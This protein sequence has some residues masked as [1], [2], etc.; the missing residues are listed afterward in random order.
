[1][2]E[3]AIQWIQSVR[4]ACAQG[5]FNPAKF[6]RNSMAVLESIPEEA[7][8]QKARTLELGDIYLSWESSRGGMANWV[9]HLRF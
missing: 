4:Q 5:G 7:Y 8:A 1:M 9:R 3:L 2:E 6:I